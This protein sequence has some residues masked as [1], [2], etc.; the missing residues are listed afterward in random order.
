MIFQVK[1]NCFHLYLL[2]RMDWE[3]WM[4]MEEGV[5]IDYLLLILLFGGQKRGNMGVNT[6]K[7]KALKITKKK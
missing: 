1:G 5:R 4:E 6:F 2:V 3:N 7:L